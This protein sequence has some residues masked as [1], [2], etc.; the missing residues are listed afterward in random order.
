MTAITIWTN[1]GAPVS[2]LK[3]RSTIQLNKSGNEL[4]GRFVADV[5]DSNGNPIA[6]GAGIFQATRIEVQLP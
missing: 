5:L 4:T 2:V 6:Q 1:V 3:A